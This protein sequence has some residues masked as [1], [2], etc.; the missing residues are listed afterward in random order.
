MCGT[1]AILALSLIMDVMVRKGNQN[2]VQTKERKTNKESNQNNLEIKAKE[3]MWGWTKLHECPETSGKWIVAPA[4]SKP[5]QVLTRVLTKFSI[6]PPRTQSPP[7]FAHNLHFSESI[8]NIN[9]RNICSKP[10]STITPWVP[11]TT[12]R[13]P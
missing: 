10:A 11:Q 6:S 5:N 4:Q 8:A 1:F 7:A 13:G 3:R 9:H 2:T 12:A